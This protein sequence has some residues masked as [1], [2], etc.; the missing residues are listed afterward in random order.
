MSLRRA[1]AAAARER[2][3]VRDDVMAVPHSGDTT[4]ED[5]G[6]GDDDDAAAGPAVKVRVVQ[7]T[8]RDS[9]TNTHVEN[10]SNDTDPGSD[11]SR[12]STGS[13][14]RKAVHDRADPEDNR[15][16]R[17]LRPSP[18]PLSQRIP[19]EEDI[20]T[21]AGK[22]RPVQS[23][24]GQYSAVL[25]LSG[26]DFLETQLS[27]RMGNCA[28]L[29]ALGLRSEDAPF[30]ALYTRSSTGS[31]RSAGTACKVG[32][33]KHDR[34]WLHVQAHAWTKCQYRLDFLA[35]MT[36]G[37]VEQQ[38]Q[39]CGRNFECVLKEA[40][41]HL[42]YCD[43]DG[44]VVAATEEEE[45]G[46]S[47]KENGKEKIPTV[48]LKRKTERGVLKVIEQGVLVVEGPVG[49]RSPSP[50]VVLA[51]Q[52]TTSRRVEA[53]TVE[54]WES[55]LAQSE[56]KLKKKKKKNKRMSTSIPMADEYDQKSPVFTNEEMRRS[57]TSIR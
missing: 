35:A 19:E 47:E 27:C 46:Q 31:K 21:A 53:K 2:R 6:D 36:D 51:T 5:D 13:M 9:T 10:P 16:T 24:D 3:L 28:T 12:N 1:E 20:F 15:P 48:P 8:T 30:S 56:K 57:M 22:L 14:K 23:L 43:R 38:I 25:P 41:K 50:Q 26:R 29:R 52:T 55:P 40:W 33:H 4:E 44:E 34:D 49:G 17:R 45:Q 11:C 18:P 32:T 37:W 7:S 42:W 39:I 54:V